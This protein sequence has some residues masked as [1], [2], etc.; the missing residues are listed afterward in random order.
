M[1]HQIAK[2]CIIER[3]TEK[4]QTA[5]FEQEISHLMNALIMMELNI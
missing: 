3:E 5:P 1:I 4:R 2:K